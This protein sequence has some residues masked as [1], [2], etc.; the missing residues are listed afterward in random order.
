MAKSPFSTFGG[1]NADT[2]PHSYAARKDGG[3]LNAGPRADGA[4]KK[5]DAGDEEDVR[6]R[7]D[8][9]SGG[10]AKFIDKAIKRPGALHKATGTPKGEKI[11][12]KKV[13]KAAHSKKPRVREEARFAEEL[14]GFRKGKK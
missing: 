7:L 2:S 14:K 1:G 12:E 10:A 5:V 8:R 13:V 6:P 9:K 4:E 11:P 3:R